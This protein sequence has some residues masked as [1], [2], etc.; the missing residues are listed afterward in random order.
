MSYQTLRIERPEP[1]VDLVTIDRPEALNA[2]NDTVFEEFGHY[3]AG[4]ESDPEVRAIVLTGAGDKA[5][6]AGADIKQMVTMTPVE[7]KARSWRGMQLYDR[8]RRQPQPLVAMINGYALGGGMLIAMACDVRIACRSAQFGYPEIRLGI[9]PGTGGTVLIDRLIG[10]G[11]A[12]AICLLGERFSAERALALGLANEVVADADLRAV[13]FEKARL[14]A[15]Y[16]PVAIREMKRVLNASVEQDF[17]AAREVELEAYERV[18]ASEDRT[19]GVTAF[20]EKRPPSFT[21]H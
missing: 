17:S 16:S 6:V 14:L 20:V 12:R 1:G 5:F 15:G 7:A 11:T 4:V 13:A 8:M 9:F 19:E 21:G 3:L 10:P 2:L 18:F